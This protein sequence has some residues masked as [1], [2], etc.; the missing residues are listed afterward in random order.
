MPCQITPRAKIATCRKYVMLKNSAQT[1][2]CVKNA[3]WIYA[4][5]K[6]QMWETL[7]QLLD[8]YISTFT[9]HSHLVTFLESAELA[10]VTT[11]RRDIAVL[12]TCAVMRH[13]LRDAAT[14]EALQTRMWLIWLASTSKLTSSNPPAQPLL[15]HAVDVIFCNRCTACVNLYL[16]MWI[17]PIWSL[18]TKLWNNDSLQ[19][20]SVNSAA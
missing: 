18:T 15:G 5:Q 20:P 8:T 2:K 14:E 19:K 7:I 4:T 11:E 9:W 12:I 10:A 3:L 13:A 17:Q 1:E 6:G 16:I